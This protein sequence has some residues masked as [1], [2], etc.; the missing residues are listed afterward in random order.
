MEG[1]GAT[2][3]LGALYG[4]TRERL[5][6][7][8]DDVDDAGWAAPVPACPGWDVHAV[9]SHLVGVVEDGIAGRLQGGPPDAELSAEEV[10]RHRDD[11]PQELIERWSELAPLIEAAIS[12]HQIWP[13]VLDVVSHEHDVRG[14]LGRPGARDADVVRRGARVLVAGVDPELDVGIEVAGDEPSDTA[15]TYRLRTTPFEVLRFR[16]GRRSR[17]QV[18][19]LDWSTDP[20]P[21]VDRLFIFGPAASALAE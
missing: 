1:P 17:D 15:A 14:A 13:A 6:A 2:T 5:C 9:V 10:A 4:A 3:D 8:L 21:V 7:L 16:L 20:E 12:Q 11:A 19:A 18:I